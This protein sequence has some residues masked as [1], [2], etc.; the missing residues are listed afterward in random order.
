VYFGFT[1]VANNPEERG[2]YAYPNPFGN[3][4][5]INY[6]L[7]QT[8]NARIIL[9]N[10]IGKEIQ[11]INEGEKAAGTYKSQLDASN[12]PAGVYYCKVF[13]GSAYVVLKVVRDR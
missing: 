8:S 5:Y 2:I 13:T 12:L 1:G 3:M 10:T 7:S 4:L 11:V 9:Y 6:T